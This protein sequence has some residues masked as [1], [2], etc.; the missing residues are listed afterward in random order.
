MQRI[1]FVLYMHK[2]DFVYVGSSFK[3]LREI[4]AKLTNGKGSIWYLH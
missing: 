4:E 1:S 3:Q 2:G